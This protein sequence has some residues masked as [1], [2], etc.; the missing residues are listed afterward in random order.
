MTRTGVAA[1]VDQ[2]DGVFR[3]DEVE[4]DDP[5]GREVLVEVH[6]AGLCHSDL[7]VAS[8]DRGRS[9]PLIAGHELAGVVRAVGDAVSN[10]RVGDHV[11]G[12]E[13]RA[14]GSCSACNIGRPTL[15]TFPDSLERLP[16]EPPRVRRG[17]DR[18]NTLGVS[19]FATYSLADERQFV[20]IPAELP[21]DVAS[22][23]GCGVTT[24]VGAVLNV[25][26]VAPAERVA[27]FGLGGVGLNIVAGAALAGARQIVAVDVDQRKLEL[28]RQFGATQVVQSAGTA[29]HEAVR[30]VCPHG[31]D[32]AF[33]AV[34][35]PDVTTEAIR[36][37]ASG[38]T[39]Y[40]IGI[41]KPGQVL[42]VDTMADMIG[43]QRGIRGIY[44]GGTNPARDIPLFAELALSG[45]L[46]I[47]QLISERITIGDI[48][49]AYASP[50][51]SGAR[52]VLTTLR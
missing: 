13:V 45:R 26:R 44:M 28:A 1:I 24:G 43:A 42:E 9:L 30:A 18:I 27:V 22:L 47:A 31:V 36:S 3:I 21:F 49:R 5:R 39:T 29:T 40:L 38:G 35:I 8:V 34:G 11:V 2:L 37:T 25:A 4:F 10:L 15:C 23:L 12:T 32:H 46:P 17:S 41:P 51:A 20:R 50:A 16:T 7:N 33:D 52:A 6:A 48:N 19:A 14:C